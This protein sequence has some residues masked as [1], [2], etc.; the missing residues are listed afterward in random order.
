[1]WVQT[2]FT[3]VNFLCGSRFIR[4]KGCDKP[5]WFWNTSYLLGAFYLH[6]SFELCFINLHGYLYSIASKVKRFSRGFIFAS[7]FFNISHGFTFANWL[8]VDF[9]QGFIFANISFINVLYNLIF[10][11]FVLQL[12]VVVTL[13]A[14]IREQLF[15]SKYEEMVQK[16]YTK[17]KEEGYYFHTNRFWFLMESFYEVRSH[18]TDALTLHKNTP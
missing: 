11:W 18:L 3:V 14:T 13:P 7:H 4:E 17:P 10:S 16:L 5:L 2:L 6:L 9:S 12:V 1:M 15:C 8:P